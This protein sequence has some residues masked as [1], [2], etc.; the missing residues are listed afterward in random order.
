MKR[1]LGGIMMAVGILLAGASG[2]CSILVFLGALSNAFH[3][4]YNQRSII[5]NILGAVLTSG[6]SILLFAAIPFTMGISIYKFGRKLSK[7]ENENKP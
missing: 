4:G 3:E 2:L 5:P 1:L 6:V 7:P